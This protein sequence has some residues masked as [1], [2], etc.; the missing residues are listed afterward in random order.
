MNHPWDPSECRQRQPWGTDWNKGGR[1]L[2]G[3]P[4]AVGMCPWKSQSKT[5]QSRR[6]VQ[7]RVPAVGHWQTGGAEG[8][9]LSC[10]ADTQI[11][12]QGWRKSLLF[13]WQWL[14]SHNT[15]PQ[16]P[17]SLS[18]LQDWVWSRTGQLCCAHA[19]WGRGEIKAEKRVTEKGISSVHKSSIGPAMW[20]VQ[21]WGEQ[22]KEREKRMRGPN[23]L[24]FTA[25]QGQPLMCD[26]SRTSVTHAQPTLRALL[27]RMSWG[28]GLSSSL[29]ADQEIGSGQY[30][31]ISRPL[32]SDHIFPV[33]TRRMLETKCAYAWSSTSS[34]ICT[35]GT[36]NPTIYVIIKH[37]K[38][39]SPISSGI[40]W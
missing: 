11:K 22:E 23:L 4:C 1:P 6:A 20:I 13:R 18:K 15:Q 27:Q 16:A 9:W 8:A 30:C 7:W 28:Q 25:N 19:E 24:P 34:T 12:H 2:R 17:H 32:S 36:L 29:Q 14:T 40:N 39:L 33:T 26:F 3:L 37:N 31:P 35:E 38:V 5:L 21:S 10:G